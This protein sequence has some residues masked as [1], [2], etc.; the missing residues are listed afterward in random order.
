MKRA[1]E[2]AKELSGGSSDISMAVDGSWHKR[3]YTVI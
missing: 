3:G 2:E 1:V